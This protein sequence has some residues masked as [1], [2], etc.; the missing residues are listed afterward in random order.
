MSSCTACIGSS[1]TLLVLIFIIAGLCYK[2]TTYQPAAAAAAAKL[3]SDYIINTLVTLRWYIC[4][5]S[6]SYELR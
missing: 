6:K 4:K 1:V 2:I 5:H 3:S